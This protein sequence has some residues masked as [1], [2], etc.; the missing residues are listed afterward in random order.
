MKVV[1]HVFGL[2]LQQAT[3]VGEV[4]LEGLVR[5]QVLEI[6]RMRRH[7][8]TRATRQREGVLEL[9][10]NRQNVAGSGDR[11]IERLRGVAAAASDHALPPVHD[12][13][14]RIV[15]ARPNFTIVAQERIC[16]PRQTLQRFGVVR[17][18]RLVR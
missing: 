14:H 18:Q 9:R 8:G 11:Q 5:Q 13:R 2:Y 15:V 6:A 4:H 1:G 7:A 16:D 17:G 3:E 12:P 10:A